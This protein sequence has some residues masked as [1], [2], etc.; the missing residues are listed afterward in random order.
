MSSSTQGRRMR[1]RR[2]AGLGVAA[3]IAPLLALSPAA[4]V[5]APPYE[6][7]ASIDALSFVEESVQDR[8]TA[9]LTGAWSLPDNPTPSAGFVIDL[10]E[11]LQGVTDQFP[12]LSPEGAPM[13]D[14][15]VT[16]TQLFCDFD[17]QYILDHPLDLHGEF[18]FWVR[19]E[20]R[21]TEETVVS[22][23][24]EDVSAEVTVEP[25]W[26]VCVDNCDF[27]GRWN[28]KWGKYDITDD[29]IAWSVSIVS[30]TT[31]MAGG[32]TV[33]VVDRLGDQQA[34]VVGGTRVLHTN[35]VTTFEGGAVGPTGW[36]EKPADEYSVSEDGSTVTFVA[37][38]GYFYEVEYLVSVLD[39]GALGTYVNDADITIGSEETVTVGSTVRSHGGSGTGSGLRVGAFGITKRVIG[40][41]EN[42]EGLT[43]SGAFTVT[44]P[45]GAVVD[46]DFTVQDGE[47]WVS[48][49]FPAGSRVVLTELLPGEPENID[50]AEAQFSQS[51]FV[52]EGGQTIAVELTNEATARLGQFSIAKRIEGAAELV[53]ADAEF[54]VAYSYP[55]GPGYAG[56]SGLITV[57]ADGTP[58]LSPAVPVGATVTLEEFEP[59]EVPGGEWVSAVLDPSSVTIG[60]GE[61]IQVILTNIISEIPVEPEP[62]EPAPSEP[63]PSEPAPS[64]SAPSPSAPSEPE[65]P[66]T[67][68]ELNAGVT[69]ALALLLIAGGAVLGFRRRAEHVG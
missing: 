68:S 4:A 25:G 65:L 20:T 10:R 54:V 57:P 40:D 58:V 64:P 33:T 50:W 52:I 24:F 69:V 36:T 62:S 67:G 22:F 8:T 43:F 51:E 41:T 38:A 60:D 26:D 21:V 18:N 13:G 61:V 39:G 56:G 34:F 27:H 2:F 29:T 55:G 31:G 9:E 42:L 35:V 46:G 16:E 14:C 37:E 17:D 19:V 12:L 45:A 47:T 1:L 32:E 11:E 63:A 28:G 66:R 49:V 3:L 5:A 44:T 23:E 48:G 53:P 6:T 15:T 7:E 59:A 30:P